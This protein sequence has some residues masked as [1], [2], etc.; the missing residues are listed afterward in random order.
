MAVR[1][2]LI[3]APHLETMV[4]V[5]GESV[6]EREVCAHAQQLLPTFKT[7]T[8]QATFGYC[9]CVTAL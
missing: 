4:G 7:I 6:A 8:L 9:Y 3:N 1:P 5:R 2:H